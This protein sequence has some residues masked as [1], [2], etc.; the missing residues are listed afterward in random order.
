LAFRNARTLAN[1]RATLAIADA[2]FARA[3][4]PAVRIATADI[5]GDAGLPA[6]LRAALALLLLFLLAFFGIS[7]MHDTRG[8]DAKYP[9]QPEAA[10]P[11]EMPGH[12]GGQCIELPSIHNRLL[13]HVANA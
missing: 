11:G 4:E 6:L 1:P 7:I 8:R 13:D 2:A 10:S 12:P 5:L 3:L 9:E